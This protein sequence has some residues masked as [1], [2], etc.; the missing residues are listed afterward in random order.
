MLVELSNCRLIRFQ[1]FLNFS[2][3]IS[4]VFIWKKPKWIGMK[5][6]H[7]EGTCNGCKQYITEAMP[8][9][10]YEKKQPIFCPN[11]KTPISFEIIRIEGN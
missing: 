4:V 10:V 7:L 6:A 2:N 1:Q 8:L 9:E 11:C 5:I 3:S